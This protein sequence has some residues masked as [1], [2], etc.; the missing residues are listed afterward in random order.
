MFSWFCLALWSPCLGNGSWLLCFLWFVASVVSVIA[1]ALPL[2]IIGK[3]C[4]VIV[5]SSLFYRTFHCCLIVFRLYFISFGIIEPILVILKIECRL[6]RRKR[7]GDGEGDGEGE[8]SM[9]TRK[10]QC[11]IWSDSIKPS[12]RFSWFCVFFVSKGN[13]FLL[14][15]YSTAAGVVPCGGRKK[16]PRTSS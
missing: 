5:T 15:F 10:L 13:P 4:S 14:L 9:Q 7:R 11:C 3:L 6:F 1:F 16:S 12:L 8:L 2:G